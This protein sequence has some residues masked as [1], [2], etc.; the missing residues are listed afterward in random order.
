MKGLLVELSRDARR[1]AFTRG[2]ALVADE[3][4]DPALPR[5][6]VAPGMGAHHVVDGLRRGAADAP[7]SPADHAAGSEGRAGDGHRSARPCDRRRRCRP[8]E[9]APPRD[10]RLGCLICGRADSGGWFTP[11]KTWTPARADACTRQRHPKLRHLP[12]PKA[13]L[14]VRCVDKD[15]RE[16]CREAARSRRNDTGIINLIPVEFES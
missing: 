14:L 7:G 5:P 16:W 4:V 6:A 1:A 13:G 9:H 3:L 2:G 10:W 8:A 12:L 11:R 15:G